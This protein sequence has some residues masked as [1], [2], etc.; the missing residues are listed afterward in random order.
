MSNKYLHSL[1]AF[2]TLFL[3]VVSG[4]SQTQCPGV[5]PLTGERPPLDPI[6]NITPIEKEGDRQIDEEIYKKALNAIGF[7]E[8]GGGDPWSN[9]NDTDTISMGFLQW[10]WGT[11]SLIDTLIANTSN[12]EIGKADSSIQNDIRILKRYAT[13]RTSDNKTNALNVISRWKNETKRNKVRE[14]LKTDEM[15]RVQDQ[16]IRKSMKKAFF[17]ARAWLRDTRSERSIDARTV[18]YFFDLIV[19]NGNTAGIWADHVKKF[20]SNFTNKKETVLAISNWLLSCNSFVAPTKEH[21]VNNRVVLARYR[22]LYAL[23][24]STKSANYWKSL[25]QDNETTIDEN[26]VN[27]L[28]FGLLRAQQSTGDDKPRAFNGVFQANVLNRRGIIAIGG[29]AVGEPNLIKFDY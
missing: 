4:F 23:N 24:D 27:L 19:F 10:N 21:L 2:F 17:Y 15:K 14:W 12:N 5:N 13:S 29:Y 20:R 11:S 26:Q 6:E 1:M 8:A 22:K 18:V 3:F 9:V 25:V 28:V 7:F 16:I